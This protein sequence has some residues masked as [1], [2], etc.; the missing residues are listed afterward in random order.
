[1]TIPADRPRTNP[2]QELGRLGQQVWLDDIQRSF[3]EDGDLAGLIEADGL[4]GI[5]SNPVIFEHA[6][7]QSHDYDAA[8]EQLRAERA[9]SRTAYERLALEDIATAADIFRPLYEATDAQAGFVSLE[10]SPYLARDAQGTVAEGLRLWRSLDRPNVFIKVPGTAEG[11]A[12]IA[13][14]VAEGVN[15]NVTLLFGVSRYGHVA[16]AYFQGLEARLRM[17][18]PI[19]NVRS[20]ASFFLSRIDATVDRRLGVMG[21]GPT[22][23]RGRAAVSSAKLAYRTFHS[24]IRSERWRA[25]AERG[26]QPQKLL[27]ASTGTKDPTFSDVKYVEELIGPDTITTL[28]R[29]TLDAFR[30]HGRPSLTLEGGLRAA[31]TALAGLAAAGI[32]METVANELEEE[33]IAL[34]AKAFDNLDAALRDRLDAAA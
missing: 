15:V 8:L 16:E 3:L 24:L 31:E 20:V 12:A 2:L 21:E 29:K 5:T 6:I 9:D 34:F 23:L 32:D 4:A 1:M 11:L 22:A 28:P 7:R 13:A 27:W 14:L 10:V 25:L 30:D 17:G 26:G 19:E 18:K 33:G